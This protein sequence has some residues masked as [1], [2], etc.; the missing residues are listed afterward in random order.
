VR[1]SQKVMPPI[2]HFI[3]SLIYNLSKFE[4]YTLLSV[5]VVNIAFI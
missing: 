2:V 5:T 4:Y 3:I 1:R